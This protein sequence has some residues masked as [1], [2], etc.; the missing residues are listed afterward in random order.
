MKYRFTITVLKVVVFIAIA[1]GTALFVNKLNNSGLELAAAETEEPVLPIAYVQTEGKNINRMNGYRQV[2]STEFMRRGIVPVTDEKKVRFVVKDDTAYTESAAY[3]LRS[4]SGDTLIERGDAEG[5]TDMEGNRI[6]D[7]TLRMDLSLNAEYALCLILNKDTETEV[8]YYTRIVRTKEVHMAKLLSFVYDFHGACFNKNYDPMEGNVVTKALTELEN[9]SADSLA[10]VDLTSG[11]SALSY[12][13]LKLVQIT[14]TVPEVTE[15][16]DQYACITCSFVAE[17]SEDNVR[18]CY[19]VNEYYTVCYNKSTD[20]VELLAFDRYMDSFFD[21]HSISTEGNGLMLGICCEDSVT[22]RSTENY[23]KCALVKQGQLWYYD[24]MESELLEVFSFPRGTYRDIRTLNPDCD[25]NILDMDENGNIDFVVYGYI[26]R[27][28][29]EGEN[30]IMLLRFDNETRYVEEIFFLSCDQPFDVL[31]REAGRFTYYDK[32][33]KVFYCLLHGALYSID[34]ETMEMTTLMSELPSDSYA[35]SADMRVVAYPTGE[36]VLETDGIVIHDFS[37]GEEVKKTGE[38]NDRFKLLGFVNSD[39]IYG[40]AKKKDIIVTSYGEAIPPLYE[41]DIVN[42][43]GEELK[44]YD[45]T[46]VYVMDAVVQTDTIYLSRAVKQNEFFK[47]TEPDYI[48]YNRELTGEDIAIIEKADPLLMRVKLIS[49]PNDMYVIADVDYRRVREKSRSNAL[50]LKTAGSADILSYRVYDNAGFYGTY[51]SCG[52]AI[53]V[54]NE[55]GNGLVA[56]ASGNTVYRYVEADSYNTVADKIRETKAKT[57]KETLLT[58]AYMCIRY[59]GYEAEL[60]EV[61]AAESYEQAFADHTYGV[62][63]NISGISL[64]TALYFLDR[65][66]PFIA[67]IGDGHYVLVISYNSTHIRYYDPVADEEVKVEREEFEELLSLS[68]NEM[69]TYASQ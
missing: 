22:Y 3:E 31:K 54:V 53:L 44:S 46:G 27:G 24:Y 29:H 2:M 49:F 19:R 63:L 1:T 56:D 20:S 5:G 37:T 21:E 65:D 15:L 16:D 17:S 10:H 40:K 55:L 64:S 60:S 23:R 39:V 9:P 8:R 68:G 33:G 42:S 45:K 7:V 4:I 25:I 14:P 41:I 30:G 38:K 34:T 61:L 57:K 66:C 32:E 6:L 26:S 36:N 50:Q 11:Y 28:H 51:E 62:G 48:S 12:G 47:D 58:C 69:Y 13:D 35:V 52:K 59:L 67:N 43:A 18:H